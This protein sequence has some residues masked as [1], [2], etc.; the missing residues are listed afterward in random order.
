MLSNFLSYRH[1]L[2]EG[3]TIAIIGSVTY[4]VT[5]K[6]QTYL[7]KQSFGFYCTNLNFT[8]N[9]PYSHTKVVNC[10]ISKFSSCFFCLIVFLDY[11]FVNVC[12]DAE[13]HIGA[14]VTMCT[15]QHNVIGITN[16]PADSNLITRNM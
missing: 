4:K 6:V 15:F 9:L 12:R 3:K 8:K 11:N 16:V 14:Q 10:K 2:S 5:R 7:M 13:I 1:C